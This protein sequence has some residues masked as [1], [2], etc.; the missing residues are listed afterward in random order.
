MNEL[1]KKYINK[2]KSTN[3]NYGY[4]WQS[5]GNNYV[6][7]EEFKDNLSKQKRCLYSTLTPKDVLDIKILLCCGISRDEISKEYDISK[8]V[9]SQL[10]NNRNFKYVFPKAKDII[11]NN[12]KQ[13]KAEK[14]E[15][16][17]K[18][19]KE[20]FS[21]TQISSKLPYSKSVIEKFIYKNTKSVEDKKK[22][23]QEIF[24][25]VHYLYKKNMNKYQIS[26]ILNVSPSTVD[27][28][29]NKSNNPY[30][31]L[32]YKKMTDNILQEILDL[33]KNGENIQFLAKKFNISRQTISFYIE[34]YANTEV[35]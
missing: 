14:E 16:I 13:A 9:L 21:I 31:E 18:L 25:K 28:Y 1:E 11:K 10:I 29:L 24:D 15:S 26:K 20:G 19:Y 34:K 22:K 4:N 6:Y 30:N 5:G 3:P 32:N 35:S 33:Y 17:L 23:Y 7:N 27:R 2:Y 8:E 12:E